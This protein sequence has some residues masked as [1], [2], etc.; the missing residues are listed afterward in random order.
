MDWTG[1]VK[2]GFVNMDGTGF[3]RHGFVKYGLEWICKTWICK[4]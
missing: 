3:V 4:N 1:F 2:H